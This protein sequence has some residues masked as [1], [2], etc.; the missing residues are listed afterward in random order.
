[1][2]LLSLK[3]FAKINEC[4]DFN[5]STC[6]DYL[7]LNQNITSLTL[8]DLIESKQFVVTYGLNFISSESL[9]ISLVKKGYVPIIRLVSPIIF[10]SFYL[11]VKRSNSLYSDYVCLNSSLSN[12][13]LIGVRNI[14]NVKSFFQSAVSNIAVQFSYDEINLVNL[15]LT[16]S[17]QAFGTYQPYLFTYYNGNTY[18]SQNSYTKMITVRNIDQYPFQ[19][20][21][22]LKYFINI[23]LILTC[24]F[25]FID[26]SIQSF[27]L[28]CQF[29]TSTV[30][31]SLEYNITNYASSNQSILINYADG[32]NETFYINPYC[33]TK[34]MF[35][36]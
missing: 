36:I 3:K 30:I 23:Y 11:V 26:A 10:N 2:F 27:N 6:Q 9:N 7:K 16:Y 8:T 15:T 21:H 24:T 14:T 5:Q 28:Q 29:L 34:F 12:G 35:I 13:T 20:S 19:G 31:C 32:S 1:M 33:K 25:F 17:Y 18:K 4:G 22:F